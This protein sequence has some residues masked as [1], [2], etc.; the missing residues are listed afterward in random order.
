MTISEQAYWSE[1]TVVQ[2]GWSYM[3][4]RTVERPGCGSKASKSLALMLM[5]MIS[6]SM[7]RPIMR[8]D[9]SSR[10]SGVRSSI[11]IVVTA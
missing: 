10:E 6:A 5:L 9:A 1:S 3:E 11:S 4:S 8:R 7:G 2:S